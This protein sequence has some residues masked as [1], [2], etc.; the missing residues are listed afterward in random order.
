M[1]RGPACALL[2]A[3]ASRA[4]AT[5]EVPDPIFWPS[6]ADFLEQVESGQFLDRLELHLLQYAA[7]PGWR[8]EW[9]AQRYAGNGLFGEYG[10]TTSRELYVNSQIALNLFPAEWLQIRYDRRDYQEGRFD[11]SDQRLDALFY[12]GSGFALVF[13]GWPTFQKESASIGAGLRIGAARSR[14][15]LELRVMNERWLW[16][17]KSGSDFRITSKPLRLLADGSYEAGP[18]RV[19]GSIDWGL[20]YTAFVRG[21]TDPLAGSTTRGWQRFADVEGSYVGGG[22]AAGARVTGAGLDREQTDQAGASWRL[23]RSWRRALVWWREDLGRWTA[24]ALAGWSTQR[25]D[26]SSPAAPSGVYVSDALLWGAEGGRQVVR[27]LE[28]RLGYLG[29]LE[30]AERTLPIPG[31]LPE[32]RRRSYLDKAHVRAVYA[33]QPRMS[34]EML[35]SQALR[36]GRFGGGSVKALLVF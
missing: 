4:A 27:G 5:G 25:D 11:F 33:F 16:N 18:W 36:G 31:P 24:S 28:V 20:E 26:F 7:D 6:E 19:H 29:S 32:E 35:L 17:Q 1:V 21:T 15:A 22:W 13:S 14:N 3:L 2:V 9:A 30:R 23:D 8:S 12:A 34:I 10:S